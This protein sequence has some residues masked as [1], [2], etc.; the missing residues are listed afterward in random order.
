MS[1]KKHIYLDYAATTPMLGAARD[2][3][4][5]GFDHW[6]NPS[7]PHADGRRAQS[8]LEDARQRLK[9]LLNWE[10]DV[11]FTSGASEAISIALNHSKRDVCLICAAEHEVVERH[12]QGAMT[13]PVN[14]DGLA[15]H[16]SLEQLLADADG[17]ALVCIQS[18]NN[19]TGVIQDIDALSAIVRASGGFMVTDCAQSAA[20][21][22]LPD[23]DMIV[24]A[25][26][27]FGGPPGVGAL[28]VK[29]LKRLHPRGGQEQGYRSGTQNLPYILAMIAALEEPADWLERAKGLR[30]QLDAAIVQEGGAIISAKAPRI[31]T[32]GSYHMPGVAANT[33]LIKFDMAGF[34]VSAGS[35]C[36]SGTLK[37]SHVLAA[38]GVDDSIAREVIRVSIGRQTT[39]TEIAAFIDRWKA[40]H[41]S[42]T[43][44]PTTNAAAK[45]A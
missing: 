12:S 14:G 29:D 32:I 4:V 45:R 8:M 30:K 13:I 40:I 22:P 7:S 23:A 26:H 44:S 9:E 5:R 18:V 42:A 41:V 36:S 16:A 25:A 35:A 31:A 27:K 2:A 17:T 28:L 3:C 37:S 38:M 21:L 1:D 19:E 15:D 20:K 39:Q 10:G 11:L 43:R 6:A 24:V 34:S 33:Q